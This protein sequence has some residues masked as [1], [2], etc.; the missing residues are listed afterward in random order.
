M[1]TILILYGV[2]SFFTILGWCLC[3]LL[4]PW[5]G[6]DGGG[7][8]DAGPSLDPLAEEEIAALERIWRERS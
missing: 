2:A 5:P 8:P 3:A 7:F 1:K 6:D 4:R